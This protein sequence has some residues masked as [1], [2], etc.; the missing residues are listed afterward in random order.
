MSGG[1]GGKGANLESLGNK[2][3]FEDGAKWRKP[4]G[5]RRKPP[6]FP[7]LAHECIFGR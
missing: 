4:G 5:N 6:A 2:A 3:L 7:Y 1:K